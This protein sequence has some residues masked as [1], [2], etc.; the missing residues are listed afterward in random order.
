[1]KFRELYAS[2]LALSRF[3]TPHQRSFWKCPVPNTSSYSEKWHSPPLQHFL[4]RTVRLEHRRLG[5]GAGGPVRVRNRDQPERLSRLDARPIVGRGVDPLQR[6][7]ERVVGIRV[8]V[9]PAIHRDRDDVARRIEAA[10]T[11]APPQLVAD[12]PLERVER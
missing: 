6:I 1:M 11:E 5:A 4:N 7:V 10:I 12:L 2:R 3:R 9:R 8:A